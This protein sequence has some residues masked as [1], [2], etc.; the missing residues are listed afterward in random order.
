MISRH[1]GPI[2]PRE[3]HPNPGMDED[4][5]GEGT[6]D[7]GIEGLDCR[8]ARSAPRFGPG[9][10]GIDSIRGAVRRRM[11]IWR[12]LAGPTDHGRQPRYV[13]G[14]DG[15]R[16]LGRRTGPRRPAL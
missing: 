12:A 6:A 14:V 7:P 8:L 16:I 1:K 5:D 10:S 3:A 13:Q 9:S 4:L 2:E 11:A 15:R